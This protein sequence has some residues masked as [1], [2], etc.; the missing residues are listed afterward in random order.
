ML[1]D[2]SKTNSIRVRGFVCW[3]KE[4]AQDISIKTQDKKSLEIRDLRFEI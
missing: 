3:A 2:A 1:K 4:G